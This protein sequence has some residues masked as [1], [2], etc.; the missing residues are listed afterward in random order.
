M[1]FTTRDG[2]RLYWRL[3][4]AA[5]RPVLVLLNSIGTDM[6]LWA[7]AFPHLLPVFRLLRIDTRGHGASD[8]PPGDYSLAG[9]ARDVASVMDAAGWD[10]A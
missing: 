1:A 3:D 6:A 5:A 2:V 9:L 4:G 7:P 8:A 10:R